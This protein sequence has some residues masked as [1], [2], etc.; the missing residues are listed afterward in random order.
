MKN[1][2]ALSLFV[3]VVTALWLGGAALAQGPGKPPPDPWPRVV[4]LSNAQVLA[5]QPQIITWI[6]NQIEFRAVQRPVCRQ[7][8][9]VLIGI[10]VAEHHLLG[11][12]AGIHDRTIDR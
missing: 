3:F 5:Y 1:R 6:D 9:A 12:V 4:D 8:T 2:S 10:G 11:T 7:V